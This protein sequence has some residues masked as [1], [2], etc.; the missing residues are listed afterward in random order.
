[1]LTG[2]LVR[3]R[4]LEPEDAE[5]LYRWIHDPDVGRWMNNDHPR[6]LAQVRKRCEE[7]KPNTYGEVVL[8]IETVAE[9]KLIGVTDLRDARPEDGR[10]ELDIYIGETG[11]WDGG[12]GTEALKL[13]CRYGFNVMRLHLIALWV[14]AE[15]E[16]AR[17]VYRKA[18]FVED[19]RHRECFRGS[20]GKYH[21]MYLMS[22]LEP[23]LDD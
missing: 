8:G 12:Y 23:E 5:S 22:L 20:D 10:A 17:H 6:S 3:L 11:H 21:D 18:G 16:R 2:K 15:N 19:G 13:L 14:V 7:R 9:G 4:A 1:M